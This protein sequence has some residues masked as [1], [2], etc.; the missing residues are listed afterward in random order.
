MKRLS[1]RAPTPSGSFGEVED[2]EAEEPAM[3]GASVAPMPV[4]KRVSSQTPVAPEAEPFKPKAA[5]Q[6]AEK[7]RSGVAT[8]SDYAAAAAPA[9]AVAVV[10]QYVLGFLSEGLPSD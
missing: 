9:P 7:V 1:A 2:G 4:L 8:A 10:D 3:D 6:G 5:P